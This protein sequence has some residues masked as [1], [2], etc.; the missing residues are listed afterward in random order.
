MDIDDLIERL[1]RIREDHGCLPVAVKDPLCPP[2]GLKEPDWKVD[3]GILI[4][5]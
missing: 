5:E 1:I 3:D 2:S 4:L